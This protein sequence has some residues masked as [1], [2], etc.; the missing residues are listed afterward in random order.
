VTGKKGREPGRLN[1]PDGVDLAPPY[2]L[3]MIHKD[4]MGTP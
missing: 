2:S 3:L 4:T 1:T